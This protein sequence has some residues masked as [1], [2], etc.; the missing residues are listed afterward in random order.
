MKKG[1]KREKE[2]PNIWFEWESKL[3]HRKPYE[4]KIYNNYISYLII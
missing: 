2:R 4:I 3:L 1:K